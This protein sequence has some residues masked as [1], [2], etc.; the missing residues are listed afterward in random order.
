MSNNG[1]IFKK[2]SEMYKLTL[3]LFLLLFSYNSFTQDAPFFEID[4]EGGYVHGINDSAIWHLNIDTISNPN[5]I[6]QIGSPQK[7]VFDSALSIPNAIVTDTINSYPV[8]DTSSFTVQYVISGVNSNGLGLEFRGYYS[9]NS[10]SLLDYGKIEFSP[11][12]GLSWIDLLDTSNNNFIVW[13]QRPILTGNSN[14]WKYYDLNL[15]NFGIALGLVSGDT[16]LWRFSFI[17]D[18]IN[19]NKDGLMFDNMYFENAYPIGLIEISKNDKISSNCFPN[20]SNNFLNIELNNPNNFPYDLCIYDNLGRKVHGLNFI[21]VEEIVIDVR[22]FKNG[23]YHYTL[24]CPT[25]NLRS[26]GKFIKN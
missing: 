21:T 24:F 14:G 15:T 16:I 7:I 26:T 5:N 4:F 20:P 17:S 10:D 22:D 12:N 11:N 9:V 23:I 3:P 1:L 25:Q 18:G 6:W 2:T 13:D 19:T 8:N